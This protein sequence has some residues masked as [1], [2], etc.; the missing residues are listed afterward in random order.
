MAS[1]TPAAAEAVLSRREIAAFLD[2]WLAGIP[3]FEL[4]PGSHPE[5]APGHVNGVTR[6][7]L[8]WDPATTRV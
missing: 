6:V 1:L 3:E 4:K 7:E 5:M 8:V 2:E